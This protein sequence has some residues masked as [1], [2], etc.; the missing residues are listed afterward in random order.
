MTRVATREGVI[1]AADTCRECGTSE[2]VGDGRTASL[3]RPRTTNI[4]LRRFDGDDELANE[5]QA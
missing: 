2:Q 3:L 5:V 4:Y 1:T